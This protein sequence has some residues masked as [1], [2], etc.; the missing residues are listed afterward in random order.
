MNQEIM[1]FLNSPEFKQI[2]PAKANMIR[3]MITLMDGKDTNSRLQI[4][5]AYGFKMKN[6]G[7]SLT[8]EESSMM[9]AAIQGNMTPEERQKIQTL[10]RMF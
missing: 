4:L 3:E 8:Q 5:I 1:E 6:A 9:I 7:L 10:L 2:P